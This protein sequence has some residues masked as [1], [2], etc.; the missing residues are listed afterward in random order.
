MRLK[1][2]LFH[3][4][5]HLFLVALIFFIFKLSSFNFVLVIIASAL[6][7]ADHIPFISKSGVGSWVKTWS[8]HSPKEYPLHN[9]VTIFIFSV[10]SFLILIPAAFSFGIC[11]LAITTH[12]L[13]DLFEDIAIFKIG[14]EH[15]NFKY[16]K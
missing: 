12:L 8:S 14:I 10:A 11:F 16:Q 3:I 9:F 1:Y 15:W 2:F 6:I 4:S 5:I 13:W 7:D